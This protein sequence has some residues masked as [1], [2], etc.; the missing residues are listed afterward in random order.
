M[1][2]EHNIATMVMLS[3][4]KAWRYWEEPEVTFGSLKVTLKNTETLS[5][6]VKREFTVYNM[7]V[8]NFMTKLDNSNEFSDTPAHALKSVTARFRFSFGA[9]LALCFWERTY[10]QIDGQHV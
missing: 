8:I 6:Y 5:S 3:A 1:V 2:T 9:T 10:G 7:K 4:D